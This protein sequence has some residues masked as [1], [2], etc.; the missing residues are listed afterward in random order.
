[1]RANGRASG[2]APCAT[3]AP[4]QP[5][6]TG[7][8]AAAG[9]SGGGSSGIPVFADLFFVMLF[10]GQQHRHRRVNFRLG[11]FTRLQLTHHVARVF[12]MARD[13][14]DDR[15]KRKWGKKRKWE[16]RMRIEEGGLDKRRLRG[17]VKRGGGTTRKGGG[18]RG[19]V[20]AEGTG[21][22]MGR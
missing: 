15:K 2:P 21:R 14:D 3:L 13:D 9:G 17:R 5:R 6:L 22:G 10:G 16:R 12:S 18:E 19:R 4:P 1:M 11:R 7:R 20:R 8:L